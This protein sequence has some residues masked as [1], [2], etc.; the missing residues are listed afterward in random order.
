MCLDAEGKEG[1]P[2]IAWERRVKRKMR[3]MGKAWGGIQVMA[4]DTQMLNDYVTALHAAQRNGAR[5]S[6]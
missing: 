4:K 3:Q 2:K 5:V 6:E 1:H